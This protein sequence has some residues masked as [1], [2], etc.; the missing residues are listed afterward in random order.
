[1]LKSQEVLEREVSELLKNIIPTK[2]KSALLAD[3]SKVKK[4]SDSLRDGSFQKSMA[5]MGSLWGYFPH[6]MDVKV[7][8]ISLSEKL[9]DEKIRQQII[10]KTAVYC[11]KHEG[12]KVSRNRVF[13]SLKAYNGHHVSNFRPVTARDLYLSL[14]GKNAVIFD[15]CAGWGGRFIG[16]VAAGCATYFGIDASYKTVLS[17]QELIDDSGFDRAFVEYSAIEDFEIGEPCAD[18]AFTSPPYFDA[19]KYSNDGTQSWMRYKSYK[20]WRDGFLFSLLEKMSAAVNDGGF[21]AV[22][23]AD[24]KGFPLCQDTNDILAELGLKHHVTYKYILSSIAGKGE[25]Y[26]PIFVYRKGAN[27][28]YTGSNTACTRPPL[29]HDDPSFIP[30]QTSMFAEVPPAISSGR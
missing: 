3:I 18:I 28:F 12:Y 4:S 26:E 29:A 6:F 8:N 25:K 9:A 5:G 19:E 11:A 1:M 21:V 16:A 13:Q 17:F 20:E 30:L 14:V 10:K 7:G 23:I 22:N 2:D 24:V 27:R 15:P